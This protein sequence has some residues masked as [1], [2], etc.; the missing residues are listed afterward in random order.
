MDE[1]IAAAIE[2]RAKNG[3]LRC[4][5][6]FR[7]AEDLGVAP[8]AVGQTANEL[9]VRLARCQLG[10]F[11]HGPQKSITEPADEI[12]PELEQAIREGLILGRLPCAVAWA[13]AARFG[14]PKLHVANAAEGLEV[15]IGQC[16]L[17]AF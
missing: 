13:I 3:E 11:G 5:E 6:A 9:D 4:A 8:L 14:M 7:I 2:R 17:S 10:L 16:Q 15:R 1:K 12:P